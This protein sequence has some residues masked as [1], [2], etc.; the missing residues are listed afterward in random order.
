MNIFGTNRIICCVRQANLVEPYDPGGEIEVGR[1][2]RVMA[3]MTQITAPQRERDPV[4]TPPELE[5]RDTKWSIDHDR[6]TNLRDV[7]LID[8]EVRDRSLSKTANAQ[9]FFAT[10]FDGHAFQICFGI[11]DRQRAN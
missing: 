9:A 4:P 10:V 1:S 6:G 11:R 2:D 5:L 7:A 8:E 3:E